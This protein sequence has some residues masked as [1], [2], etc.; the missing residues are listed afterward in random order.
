MECEKFAAE[1][2]LSTKPV[3]AR[4][5]LSEKD[6]I[7]NNSKIEIDEHNRMQTEDLFIQAED[8]CKSLEN[9][10]SSESNVTSIAN[11]TDFQTFLQVRVNTI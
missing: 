10:I 2:R 1:S 11:N 7:R 5:T 3:S 4:E 9:A 6:V 8:S